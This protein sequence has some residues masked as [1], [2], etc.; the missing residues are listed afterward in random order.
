MKIALIDHND[1]FTYN[2]VELMRQL[3][4]PVEVLVSDKVT[5]ESL[6][7]YDK[8]ILSPGPG[9]PEDFVNIKRILNRYKDKKVILGVCLGHQAIATYFGAKL[10][11]LSQPV[12]GQPKE[13][14][15]QNSGDLFVG[16]P[17]RFE[18]GLYHSWV[19]DQNSLPDELI[20]TA[21]S[22]DAHV[23]GIQHKRWPLYGVQFHPES[24][25][26]EYGKELMQNFL[27]I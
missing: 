24:F 7:M 26:T 20:V 10:L 21:I 6:E 9:L 15:W 1:S 5:P 17:K 14:N 25:M 11:N 3:N 18:V 12:H 23:M 19:V 22:Y 4:R 8:L 16:L 2:I 27:N 13:I